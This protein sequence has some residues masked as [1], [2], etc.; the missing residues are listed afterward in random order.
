M[1][2]YINLL[3]FVMILTACGEKITNE[4]VDEEIRTITPVSIT[5]PQ[6][7]D[8]KEDL[9]LNATST[10]LLKIS[11]KAPINGY[12]QTSS[13]KIGQFVNKGTSLFTLQTKEAKSLGNTIN[14]LDNT[15][16]FTGISS[17]KSPVSGFITS[18]NH[19]IG[20]Y[21]QDGEILVEIVDKNSFGFL[22]NVPYENHLLIAKNKNLKVSLPDG[23]ILDGVVSQIMPGLDSISQTQKVLVKINSSINIPENLVVNISITKKQ[24]VNISLPKESVLA[25]ESQSEF[26]IMKMI[27]DSTAVKIPVKKGVE[28]NNRIE[29]LSPQ[30]SGNERILLSGNYGLADTALV[31]IKR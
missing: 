24:S 29:I 9:I 30:L 5:N 12:I 27:N 26:W 13:I 1:K 17:V 21:V 11:V 10:Y 3:V 6:K 19:Q 14:K 16:N 22:M 31:K 2:I 4:N 18:L 20:D 25:D 15:F 8:L 7:I 28:S 23:R